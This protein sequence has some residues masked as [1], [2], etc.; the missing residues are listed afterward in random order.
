MTWDTMPEDIIEAILSTVFIPFTNDSVWTSTTQLSQ[1]ILERPSMIDHAIDAHASLL[2]VNKQCSKITRCMAS[3][4]V[5]LT[6]AVYLGS[7]VPRSEMM[8]LVKRMAFYNS[9]IN[10]LRYDIGLFMKENFLFESS[11]AIFIHIP[12]LDAPSALIEQYVLLT[13][14]RRN[15]LNK[16]VITDSHLPLLNLDYFNQLVNFHH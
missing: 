3:K 8:T 13:K 2:Y 12:C 6:R 1:S 15:L 5:N 14:R 11:H 9:R 16:L 4:W 7:D 10:L